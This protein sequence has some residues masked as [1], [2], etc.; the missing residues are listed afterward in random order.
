[1]DRYRDTDSSFSWFD[2]STLPFQI[3]QTGIFQQEIFDELD[4][5]VLLLKI[6]SKIDHKKDLLFIYFDKNLS[7]LSLSTSNKDTAKLNGETKPLIA[8]LLSQSINSIISD[9]NRN[10]EILK[11][12]VNPNTLSIIQSHKALESKLTILNNQFRTAFIKLINS[13]FY[14]YIDASKH[15]ISLSSG[16]IQKLI[17][18]NGDY[19]ELELIIKNTIHYINTIYL[20]KLPEV[21]VIDDF[22]INTD[23]YEQLASKEEA[24][25]RYSKTIIL[26]DKLNDAVKN[27]LHNKLNPTGATV[28][29]AMEKPISAPAITDAI[30]NHKSKILTLIDQYPNRWTELKQYFKP[31]QNISMYK[32]PSSSAMLNAR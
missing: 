15:S 18:F 20:N 4:K 32:V 12:N 28:G 27:V 11:N 31:I 10:Q 30:K 6:S 7:S 25:D 19:E 14:K 22:L 5:N 17:D 1:M 13:L 8:K 16:A 24:F 26:L 29:K 2:E 21:I 3:R 9:A 23:I